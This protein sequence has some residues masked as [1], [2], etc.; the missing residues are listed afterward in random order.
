MKVPS[1][2]WTET[3]GKTFRGNHSR[4]VHFGRKEEKSKT[5]IEASKDCKGN[6]EALD[7]KCVKCKKAGHKARDC[8]STGTGETTRPLSLSARVHA[9][10]YSHVRETTMDKVLYDRRKR[11]MLDTGSEVSILPVNVLKEAME[12]GIDVDAKVKEIALPKSLKVMDASGRAMEF[13]TAVEVDVMDK[14][15]KKGISVRMLVSKAKEELIILGTNAISRMGYELKKRSNMKDDEEVEQQ[16]NPA[17]ENPAAV[18]A[19]RVFIAPGQTG[20]VDLQCKSRWSEAILNTE[21]DRIP[22]GLCK[23]NA[24]GIAKVA[25]VKHHRGAHSDAEGRESRQMG[26]RLLGQGPPRG[27]DN[28]SSL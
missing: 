12:D 7:M 28:R 1:S 5:E 17:E 6:K 4:G 25:V 18:V 3:K 19:R 10:K 8:K 23:I 13:L 16:R 22:D 20:C 14:S 15:D 2:A 27:Y 9:V 11:F 24:E 21:D 26:R